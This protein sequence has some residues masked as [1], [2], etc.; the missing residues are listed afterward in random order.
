MALNQNE[1]SRRTGAQQ[2]FG[3]IKKSITEQFPMGLNA[4]AAIPLASL[5]K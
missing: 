3:W 5:K 1:I 2:A 4:S